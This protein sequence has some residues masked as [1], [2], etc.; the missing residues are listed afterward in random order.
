MRVSRSAFYAWR[1]QPLRRQRTDAELAVHIKGIHR[2][3]RGTYGSPRITAALRREGIYVNR[4]KVARVMR[5]H[6][7][8][9]IPHRRFRG[10]TTDSNH[11]E[12]VAPELLG[13]DF[14]TTEPN[15]VWVG[16]ITYLCV[17][18]SWAYLAVLVDLFSRRV[19]GWALDSH[20]RTDL[21]SAALKQ[22]LVVR[23]PAPG[24]IH[25]SDRGVQYAS[26]AYRARLAQAGIVQ[27]MSRK[28]NCWD[29]A[30]SE[31]FFGTL[32]Q[33]LVKGAS[34]QTLTEARTAVGHYIHVFYNHERL[35]STIGYRSPV[36]CESD[37]RAS[38]RDAA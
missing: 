1:K 13:R 29:N 30:V 35:H 33:E 14:V 32:K 10:T 34:W 31:S 24:L 3:S 12:A 6:G 2:D 20:M 25:H 17:G 5:E 22:A 37:H 18:A 27:S 28:G 21:V 8:R 26:D 9:G 36:E 38:R 11:D 4:K 15:Q 16:D 7:I 19:V 23:Q